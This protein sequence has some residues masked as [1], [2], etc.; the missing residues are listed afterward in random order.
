MQRVVVVV[1]VVGLCVCVSE[2]LGWRHSEV[3]NGRSAAQGNHK[4]A[5]C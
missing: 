4:T 1:V 2:I 3:D 5:G